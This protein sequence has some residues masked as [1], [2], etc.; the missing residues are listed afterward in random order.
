M[1]QASGHTGFA[2]ASATPARGINAPRKWDARP[3]YDGLSNRQTRRNP[4]V[5]ILKYGLIG[6]SLVM[7]A[8]LFLWPQWQSQIG[9]TALE[10]IDLENAPKDST[11]L[12]A[13]FVSGGNR[14][15]NARAEK[16]VQDSETPSMV[17]LHTLEGDAS[18]PNGAWMFVSAATGAFDRN[19]QKL[20]LTG[21]VSLLADNGYEVHTEQATLDLRAG[22]ISDAGPIIGQGPLGSLEAQQFR[23]D[24][25]GDRLFF[26]G[27]VKMIITPDQ[28]DH[29]G[30]GKNGSTGGVK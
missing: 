22:E 18:L 19:S 24:Q 10:A 20:S 11:M 9:G 21:D 8:L 12:N 13:T 27:G 4:L 28:S 16:V 29:D 2:E 3:R 15:F 23:V 26:S 7:I 30:G 5:Q 6:L 14:P 25:K 1:T 17:H